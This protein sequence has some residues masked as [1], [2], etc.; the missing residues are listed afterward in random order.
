MK[1]GSGQIRPNMGNLLN[2]ERAPPLAP[3]F[4]NKLGKTAASFAVIYTGSGTQVMVESMIDEDGNP[5]E[6][7]YPRIG[8]ADFERR[9][10]LANAPTKEE[11]LYALRR[12][13]ELRLEKEFPAK[14]PASG[15]EADIQS[16]IGTLPLSERLALLKSQKDFDKSK[17]DPAKGS[18]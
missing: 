9:V 3:K 8:L 17:S 2:L 15:S 7:P 14:G 11:R 4:A 13:Y 5:L 1:S 10:A 12:K 16:W 6:E 18:K